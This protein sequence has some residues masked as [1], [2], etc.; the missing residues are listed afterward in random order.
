M[1]PQDMVLPMQAE[2]T[3]AGFQDLHNADDVNE[4]IKKEGTTLVVVNSVCGCAARNARPGAILSID[5]AKKPDQ[6]ITVFAGVDKEAVDA[7]R[8]HMFPFPPSSP[9]IALFK[10]GELVHMLERHHIEGRPAEMIA[11]NL[12]DAYNEVC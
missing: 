5:G 10:N 6:L 4:A 8:Q 11:D 1:Y 9:S 12:K 3:S 2:L 7:A